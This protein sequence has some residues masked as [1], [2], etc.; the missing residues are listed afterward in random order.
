M[1]LELW[2]PHRPA[3]FQRR[4]AAD[5]AP[6]RFR[7]TAFSIARGGAK[8]WL[9]GA[10]AADELVRGGN[11]YAIAS[12]FRQASLTFGDA[13]AA[14]IHRFGKAAWGKRFAFRDSTQE[15]RVEDKVS[16]GMLRAVGSD[17]ERTHGWK[18]SLML[19]DEPA[20]L[21]KGGERLWAALI[22]SLGKVEGSRLMVFGT[23]PASSAHFFSKLLISDDPDI[24]TH[25]Y[26][27]DPE[28]SPFSWRN[29]ARAN[30]GLRHGFP[31]RGELEMEMR[32]AKKDALALQ[33]WRSLRL[34]L[35]ESEAPQRMRLAEAGL[36]EQ[37]RSLPVTAPE[38]PTI[39]GLD[40]GGVRALTS[41]ACYWPLTGRLDVISAI[42]GIP[43][44]VDRGAADGCGP[45]YSAAA[46]EG[47]LLV[48]GG[49]RMPDVDM[50]LRTG[51]S[52]WGPPVA[53]V[54]DR[55]RR[56][57]TEDA[58]RSLPLRLHFTHG[59]SEE[60]A[61]SVAR[62]RKALAE[63]RVRPVPRRLL[64]YAVEQARVRQTVVGDLVMDLKKAEG[65]RDDP[66]A[67]SVL[68][69]SFGDKYLEHRFRGA[70]PKWRVL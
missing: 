69:V 49:M 4:L 25:V 64:D 52:E 70:S 8:T 7:V 38:G 46:Q 29:V 59:G 26:A 17:V 53:V 45:L 41:L 2:T 39:W 19:L 67:A 55:Y 33:A 32:L 15:C 47:G 37:A 6:G 62:F 31:D 43:N 5:A 12:S 22:T 44:L 42:G 65:V 9:A 36:W 60:G 20:Q 58:V 61:E 18:P 57:E 50:M 30:P 68:A 28:A 34:N 21:K 16:G 24:R 40:L 35:G 1:K 27:A 66:A 13:K 10:V 56:G 63:G 51:F 11:A 23:R 3:P 14:L 48:S 54:A